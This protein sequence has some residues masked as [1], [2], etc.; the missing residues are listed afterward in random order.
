VVRLAEGEPG[1]LVELLP[2][3]GG[4]FYRSIYALW[5]FH[6]A[7]IPHRSAGIAFGELRA[8]GRSGVAAYGIALERAVALLLVGINPS[9]SAAYFDTGTIYDVLA[10]AFFWGAFALYV[11]FR[12]A[13]RLPGWGRLAL[14]LAC[15]S[16]ALDAKEISVCC[17]LP[18]AVRVGLASA[19]ELEAR[20]IVALDMAGGSICGH[21]RLADIAY[22]IGKRYGP[23]S[24]WQVGAI[25]AALLGGRLLPVAVTLSVSAHLQASDNL[26]LAD[27]R[28]T[29][30]DAGGGRRSRRRCLLWG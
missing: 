1:I 13:G 11:R 17:P 9:F 20:G 21:R 23:D 25:P 14:V 4:L 10:Y 28:V 3:G 2:P 29:G 18:W 8:A 6:P 24:L 19:R 16:L 15:S 12:H 5:G 22:I 7:A 30:C 27:S 26:L